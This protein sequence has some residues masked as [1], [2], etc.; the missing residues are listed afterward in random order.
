MWQFCK[1][2]YL[3]WQCW[4]PLCT[5]QYW[6]KQQN[7]PLLFTWDILPNYNLVTKISAHTH[8]RLNSRI[9]PWSKLKVQTLFVVFIHTVLCKRKPRDVAKLC[10][11]ECVSHHAN[12]L[13]GFH[14]QFYKQGVFDRLYSNGAILIL[15]RGLGGKLNCRLRHALG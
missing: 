7:V 6:E 14:I 13:L 15:Q 10:A 3:W 9:L 2:T 4:F 1:T 8:T 11:H 5:V 12:P